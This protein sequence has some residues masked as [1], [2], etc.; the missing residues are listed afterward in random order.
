MGCRPDIER[1]LRLLQ[2][3]VK[4]RQTLLFSATIPKSVTEIA[5]FAM[6]PKYNFVD[7][8]S[9]D[10]KQIYLHVKQEIIVAP[11]EK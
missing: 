11:Q 3:G 7:M 1:I 5:K 8:V 10:T 2:P 4:T 9:E 6:R